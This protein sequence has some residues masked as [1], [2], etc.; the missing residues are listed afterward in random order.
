MNDYWNLY[1]TGDLENL[2]SFYI[3]KG[4]EPVEMMNRLIAALDSLKTNY[5]PVSQVDLI[6]KTVTSNLED[7]V[8]FDLSYE[9]LHSKKTI[10]HDFTLK[11][12]NDTLR[13]INHDFQQ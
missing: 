7:G 13:I 10:R 8:K 1:L 6:G 5:G 9:T 2:K 12:V 4:E 11:S 3:S